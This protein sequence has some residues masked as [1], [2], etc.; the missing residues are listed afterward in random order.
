MKA[1][2]AYGKA[3]HVITRTTARDA[4]AAYFAEFPASRKCSVSEG[5]L[6]GPFF[7]IAY[8]PGKNPFYA[9]DVTKKQV[10]GLPA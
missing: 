7:V 1:F 6:D 9:K 2:K 4:A 10:A 8:G 5:V 3:G